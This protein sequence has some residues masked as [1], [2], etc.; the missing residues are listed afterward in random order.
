MGSWNR[1]TDRGGQ[2]IMAAQLTA[3]YAAQNT[4]VTATAT[5]LCHAGRP[6]NFP[7][8][9]ANQPARPSIS[10]WYLSA[11][12]EKHL[13]SQVCS[14]SVLPLDPWS[15][16]HVLDKKG[17][18]FV[19]TVAVYT[20]LYVRRNESSTVV[21]RAYDSSMFETTASRCDGVFYIP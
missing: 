8:A 14:P 13:M 7:D 11:S 4:S 1:Q 17:F 15:K 9:P 10:P 3:A 20:Y 16:I 21:P 12:R 18:H 2:A 19:Y 6:T 5:G